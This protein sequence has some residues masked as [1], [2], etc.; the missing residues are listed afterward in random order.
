VA[1]IVP[2]TVAV[3]QAIKDVQLAAVKGGLLQAS[4]TA[5]ADHQP[6]A[7]VMISAFREDF[8]A[9]AQSATDGIAS[10]RLLP[11]DYHIAA[12][13]DNWRAES[14]AVS[15]QAGQTNRVV[16]ELSPPP[17]LTGIVRRPDGQPAAG[18]EVRIVGGGGPV[19][20]AELT[21][22][23]SGRFETEWDPRNYG[24][25]RSTPCLL[26][27]M[28][29]NGWAVAQDIDAE[30]C[31]LD[32]RLAPGLTL[33]GQ[34]KT[35]AGQPITNV[36]V[37]LIFWTGNSGMHLSGLATRTNLPGHFEI[38]ALPPGRRYGV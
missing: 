15:V 21:T 29:Q 17:K 18:A 14:L 30:T 11:G 32:L 26:V 8:Q 36:T 31:P 9:T 34:A 24:G 27:R 38:R 35:S 5:K 19:D 4:V 20:G 2:V 23:N 10:L 33:A 6:L 3:G 28:P 16:L 37:A 13:R 1:E 25:M 22:D 12:Y 7:N